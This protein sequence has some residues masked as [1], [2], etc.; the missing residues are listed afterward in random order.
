MSKILENKKVQIFLSIIKWLARICYWV[1]NSI[2]VFLIIVF[3]ISNVIFD[4]LS[5]PV[6][7]ERFL[8]KEELTVIYKYNEILNFMAIIMLL[9]LLGA[10]LDYFSKFFRT[11]EIAC[12]LCCCWMIFSQ[13]YQLQVGDIAAAPLQNIN[14]EVVNEQ[15]F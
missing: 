5:Y 10:L 9:H 8:T 13:A 15:N 6:S 1:M 11:V 3:M 4:S 12:I 2:A 7:Y 14:S